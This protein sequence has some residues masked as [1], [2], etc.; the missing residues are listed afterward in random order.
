MNDISSLRLPEHLLKRFP[1]HMNPFKKTIPIIVATSALVIGFNRNALAD[2]AA[3]QIAIQL[4]AIQLGYPAGYTPGTNSLWDASALKQGQ[5]AQAATVANYATTA[6][7]V[8]PGTTNATI[9]A[10]PQTSQFRSQY[11]AAV[12]QALTNPATV[13]IPK[14]TVSTRKTN[15]PIIPVANVTGTLSPTLTTPTLILSAVV[16]DM[17]NFASAIVGNT[18]AATMA[19]VTNS[20]G[21]FIPTWGPAPKPTAANLSSQANIN[22]FNQK[23]ASA[24]LANAGKAASTALTAACKAYVSGTQNW[25]AFPKVGN[26]SNPI[27]SNYLPNFGTTTLGQAGLTN[28]QIPNLTGLANT[29]SAVSASAIN[30]LGVGTGTTNAAVLYGQTQSNISSITAALVKAAATFQA[31][32]TKNNT[33]AGLNFYTYGS[34]SASVFGQVTQIA[35]TNN[36]YATTSINDGPNDAVSTMLLNSVINGAVSA[37]KSSLPNV[38]SV[39]SGVAQGFLASYLFTTTNAPSSMTNAAWLS[40]Y[41]TANSSFISS[42]IARAYGKP[43]TDFTG[44]INQ[45]LNKFFTD[46]QAYVSSGLTNR[47]VFANVAGAAG[48]NLATTNSS[49]TPL[50]NGVGSPVT[51]TTGL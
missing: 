6:F 33:A 15:G 35:G 47:T 21:I 50:F 43:T 41:E 25:V 17:P 38:Q 29:A 34:I 24:Q 5:L 26:P 18:V 40:Q 48:I 1:N 3:D 22:V 31:T 11:L 10:N 16:A 27:S 20:S 32:S 14:T 46:Y 4:G 36:Y 30:G 49:L 39:A 45:Q 13:T 9:V 37:V 2:A 42:A 19:G 51:D 12:Q 8:K 28:N 7:V 44:I 23:T